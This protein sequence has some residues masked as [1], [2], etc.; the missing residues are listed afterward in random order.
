MNAPPLSDRCL[1][2]LLLGL[3]V[4]GGCGGRPS[5]SDP[6]PL[7]THSSTSSAAWFQNVTS[8]SGLDFTYRNGEEANKYTILESLGGGVAFLDYD[9]DGLLDVFVIGGGVFAGPTGMDMQ[10]LPCKLYRNLGDFHFEDVTAKVGLDSVSWWYTHGVAVADYDRDGWPDLLVTGYGRIA[11]FHNEPDGSGG[12]RFVDVSARMGLKDDSWCTSAGWADFDGDGFPDLFVCH[13]CDWS[14]SKDPACPGKTPG[15]ARD[16]C[17]PQRF[18]PVLN[19]VYKNDAGKS[20]RD[21]THELGPENI[22]YGLGVLLSDVNDDGR[23]DIYVANDASAKFLFLNRGGRFEEK[24][25]LASVAANEDGTFDGSMGVD[26]GDFEGMG[27]PGLLVTNFENQIHGLYRN[28][29]QEKFQHASR[30]AGLGVLGRHLVG[31]GT[32]FIDADNDGWEDLVIA[33]GHVVRRPSLGNPM[34]QL[35]MLLRNE[36]SNG[37]RVYRDVGAAAGPYFADPKVG[38]GLAIGDLNNDGWPDLVLSHSN[39]PV[40]ILR[41]VVADHSPAHWVGIRLVGRGNRDV[42]GSTVVLETNNR[43]LTRFVKGGG[44]YLSANDP[45]LLFGL[46]VDGK[47]IRLT[48]KWSWGQTQIVEGLSPDAYWDIHEGDP[49]P[50]KVKGR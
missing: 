16:V 11:L 37:R 41:N 26:A 23:P 43:K 9:G 48:V 32:G 42:V 13:Y 44:S 28:L 49:R 34:Q 31:F 40:A 21:I 46:G 15:A 18:L 30:A 35:P 5:P 17:P 22:G 1:P 7:P 38:R 20:F 27:R 2:F 33:H 14:L 25:K 29:G 36:E 8:L 10:G 45:R 12:R 47:P 39:S 50:L 4:V 19:G 3:T 6:S 24:G